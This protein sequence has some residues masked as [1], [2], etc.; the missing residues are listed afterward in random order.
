MFKRKQPETRSSSDAILAAAQQLQAIIFFTPD[1]IVSDANDAFIKTMGYSDLS[2]IKGKH[3]SIF[4]PAE[5]RQS[6]EYQDFWPDLR[7]GKMFTGEFR[8]ISK[9]DTNVW[10]SASYAPVRDAGGRVTQVVKLA[11]DVNATHLMI[12]ALIEGLS[13]LQS[14]DFSA[15]LTAPVSPN[16]QPVWDSFNSTTKRLQD[17]LATIRAG[18]EK[19]RDVGYA[20]QETA[21]DLA[22]K[23]ADQSQLLMDASQLLSQMSEA[24]LNTSKSARALDGEAAQT[25]EKSRNGT[26]IV[27]DTVAAIKRIEDISA[28]V[29]E[30][31]E[32]IESFALQTNLL[33]LNAAVEAARAGSAGRGF[34]VVASEVR[35][36][37]TRSAE[38][39]HQ[40]ASLTRK[41][42]DEVGKGRTLIEAAGDSLEAIESGTA[43]VAS[44]VDQIASASQEQS[45]GIQN[46][47]EAIRRLDNN[48][49]VVKSMSAAGVQQADALSDELRIF[50][51]VLAQFSTGPRDRIAG[52]PALKRAR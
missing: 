46:V 33:S 2:E 26:S 7:M 27:R 31:T 17:L 36:L 43:T 28:E 52:Q 34:A 14:G 9:Q 39:S 40:I 44:A 8:R 16:Y 6:P 23:T 20:V 49:G 37:A 42:E 11:S 38:A 25:A 13:V 21:S 29:S 51:T 3:H 1:G 32:I 10:I 15:R 45:E 24:V 35:N 50:D 41:C 22:Q 5:Q 30:T 47:Q 12:G 4:V 48:V 18:S 19:L